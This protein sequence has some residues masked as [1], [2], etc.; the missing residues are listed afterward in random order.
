M[1][2]R[3]LAFYLAEHPD[4]L[5]DLLGVLTTRLDH[6]RVVYQFRKANQ[7]SLIKDYLVSVQ[8]NNIA[9]VSTGRGAA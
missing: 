5:T 8:K 3:A 4:L 1:H 6:A 2:Y 9:E 7:L